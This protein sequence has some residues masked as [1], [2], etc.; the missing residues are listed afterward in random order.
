MDSDFSE[1]LKKVLSDPEAMSKIT[2]IASSLGASSP[3]QNA[4]EKVG[5][6]EPEPQISPTIPPSAPS[7][8]LPAL[9][10]GF[11][12]S[13]DP[14]ISLLSSIKPLLREEKREKIDALTRA[15]ALASMMKNLRK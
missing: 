12:M 14:R 1:K 3:Q 5:A 8:A 6:S 7:D 11:S 15:L 4:E 13:S 9:M 10:Q 2:A